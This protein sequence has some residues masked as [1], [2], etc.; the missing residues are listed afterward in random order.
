M[1]EWMEWGSSAL[2]NAQCARFDPSFPSPCWLSTQLS[3]L[4]LVSNFPLSK[5]EPGRLLILLPPSATTAQPPPTPPPS[6]VVVSPL[7][8]WLVS[9]DQQQHSLHCLFTVLLLYFY[10]CSLSPV[11]D[12]LLSF[13]LSLSPVLSDPLRYFANTVFVFLTP[14]FSLSGAHSALLLLLNLQTHTLLFS[15]DSQASTD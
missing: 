5:R 1:N 13:S 11:S 3:T 4:L 10:F 15:G 7:L 2:L 14:G 6:V 9:P 8:F 12:R